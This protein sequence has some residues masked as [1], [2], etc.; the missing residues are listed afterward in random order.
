M[1]RVS[2]LYPNAE[3]KKFDMDY[4]CSKHIPMVQ[5]KVGAACKG[6]IVDQ[7]LSGARPG[8]TPSFIAWTHL[9]FDS[10]ETFQS[11]F[12]PHTETFAADIPNFTNIEPIFQISEVKMSTT[13]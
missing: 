5:E 8:S 4:Y 12:A 2:V 10:L 1:I 11:S 9:L 13:G 3:G 6:V 7:G